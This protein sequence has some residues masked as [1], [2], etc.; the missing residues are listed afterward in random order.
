MQSELGKNQKVCW[1]GGGGADSVKGVLQYD[2]KSQH[3]VGKMLYFYN[4]LLTW[5]AFMV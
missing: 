3:Q 5:C 4:I 2:I 1:H